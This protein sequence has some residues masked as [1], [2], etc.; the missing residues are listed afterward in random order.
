MSTHT[1]ACK[2]HSAT[3]RDLQQPLIM[4]CMVSLVWIIGLHQCVLKIKGR[5]F[6]Y[7]IQK[8]WWAFFHT[9]IIR[10]KRAFYGMQGDDCRCI[11]LETRTKKKHP[12]EPWL[13][14]SSSW[15]AIL[16]Q[17][18]WLPCYQMRAW[19][20]DSQV[21]FNNS[22]QP[23]RVIPPNW[24]LNWEVGHPIFFNLGVGFPNHP[25]LTCGRGGMSVPVSY[26]TWHQWG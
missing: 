16:A 7:S 21:F 1:H 15:S 8:R 13:R 24:W 4:P 12:G 22:Q 5:A 18:S 23:L 11:T 3:C 14:S 6:I 2:V 26:V 19:F 10:K 17:H 20:C 25:F 9:F